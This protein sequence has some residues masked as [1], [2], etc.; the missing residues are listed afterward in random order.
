MRLCIGSEPRHRLAFEAM[1][2]LRFPGSPTRRLQSPT[3]EARFKSVED[4][5]DSDVVMVIVW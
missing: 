4:D 5:S 3:F 2:E 1:A